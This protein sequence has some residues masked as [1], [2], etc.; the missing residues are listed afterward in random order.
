MLQEVQS[1]ASVRSAASIGCA[2]RGR[3]PAQHNVMGCDAC[4]G[5][6]ASGGMD[7]VPGDADRQQQVRHH[8]EP[9]ATSS[10]VPMSHDLPGCPLDFSEWCWG[11]LCRLPCPS[12]AAIG[13]C[14]VC[15]DGGKKRIRRGLRPGKYRG[16]YMSAASLS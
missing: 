12:Q 3:S 13:I 14:N 6:K 7:R 8:F 15:P 4:E 1:A 10:A 11:P 5:G 9:A 16:Q 2:V